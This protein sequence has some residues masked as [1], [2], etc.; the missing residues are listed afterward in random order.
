MQIPQ[1]NS[2]HLVLRQQEKYIKINS[3]SYN[4]PGQPT[5]KLVIPVQY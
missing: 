3:P 2:P 5:E 4:E 1:E